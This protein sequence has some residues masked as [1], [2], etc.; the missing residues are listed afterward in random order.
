MR[1]D[2][3]SEDKNRLDDIIKQKEMNVEASS[4]LNDFLS[5]SFDSIDTD[6]VDKLTVECGL[7][8][9][10]AVS[11]CF[12]EQV[13][14]DRDDPEVVKMNERCL[15]GSF[16]HLYKEEYLSNPYVKN[17]KIDSEKKRGKYTLTV[18]RFLPYEIFQVE[19]IKDDQSLDHAERDSY[20]FF[21]E[22]VDYILLLQDDT[23]WMSITPHEINSMQED[24][25]KASGDVLT[26]GLGLG[27]YPYMLSLK[28]DVK[29]IT[30]VEKDDRVIELFTRNILPQFS[31]KDKI[32]IIKGDAFKHVEESKDYDYTFVDIYHNASDA[33]DM[34]IRFVKMDTANNLHYWIESAILCYLRRFAITILEENLLGYKEKDYED[35]YDDQSDLLLRIYQ[36]LKDK[37]YTSI[38]QI[39][40]LLSEAGLKELCKK[41]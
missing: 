5:D 7:T 23:I 32:K 3:N 36:A 15:L 21:S 16:S 37:E 27:Y 13:E 24:I 11:S 20:G 39:E 6:D 12:F 41:L 25:D 2:L 40:E 31:N 26:F 19:D 35:V 4:I 33:L 18:E 30:I 14:L 8:K 29:S 1:I 34:Y 38:D 9:E 17:I 10:E 22:G 28:D